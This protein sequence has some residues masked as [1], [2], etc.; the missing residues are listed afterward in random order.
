ML[1]GVREGL[2]HDEVRG[3]LHVLAESAW[4]TDVELHGKWGT[5]G[6]EVERGLEA[7]LGQDAGWMP[8]AISR[9]SVS[10]W[11]SWTRAFSTWAASVSSRAEATR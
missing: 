2:A 4:E 8:R 7:F 11:D 9:S 3:G 5:F 6:E 1:G 10:A